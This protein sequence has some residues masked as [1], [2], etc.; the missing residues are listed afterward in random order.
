V[1][2]NGDGKLLASGHDDGTVILWDLAT[3][4]PKATLVGSPTETVTSVAFSGDGR[5]LASGSLDAIIKLW[6]V[7]GVELKAT[8]KGHKLPVS[9]VAFSPDGK[10]LA[11]VGG[12]GLQSEEWE[13]P[14]APEYEMKLWDVATGRVKA[15][16]WGYTGQM[17][18]VA[19]SPEGSLLATGDWQDYVWPASG[20]GAVRLWD[21]QA[22]LKGRNHARGAASSAEGTR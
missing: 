7:P 10:Q 21:V 17:F 2:F 6:Q 16:A 5:L 8:L 9:S 1:S 19:F 14:P 13:E 20:P 18:C 11:S 12:D 22:L 3:G 4:R 15:S